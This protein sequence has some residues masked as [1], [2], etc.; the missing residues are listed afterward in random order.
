MEDCIYFTNRTIDSGKIKAWV[1]KELC[2]EC[3]KALMSKPKDEKT[4]R[5][6]IRAK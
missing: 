6:K 1:L 4:G 2:P 5:P 3:K